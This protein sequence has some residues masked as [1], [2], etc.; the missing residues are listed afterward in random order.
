MTKP[1]K[2]TVKIKTKTAINPKI[3]KHMINGR[4]LAMKCIHENM[5]SAHDP[6]FIYPASGPVEAKDWS[7]NGFCGRGLHGFLWGAGDHSL[8]MWD[9]P[10]KWLVIEIDPTGGFDDMGNKCKFQRG[11]VTHVG[12]VKTAAEFIAVAGG[13]RSKIIAGMAT[14][15][16]RGTATA[17]DRGTATA[18]DRGT[19]TAGDSGT[20]TAG[21]RGTATAGDSGTATAGYRGTATAGDRGTATAGDRGTA[22]AGYRGTATAGDRGTATAGYSGTATA[23]DRGTATAGYSGTATAGDS[24]TATAGDSGTATAGDR[25]VISIT[26]WDSKGQKYRRRISEVGEG[27]LKPNTPYKLDGEGNFIEAVISK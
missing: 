13:N 17:G 26:F 7:D 6:K 11:V 19:A 23:G 27:G 20:A 22:T 5:V 2:K 4:V 3:E 8:A 25:G 10:T 14:A 15:G 21:D 9:S 1:K 24:G 16:D 18:G 12:D